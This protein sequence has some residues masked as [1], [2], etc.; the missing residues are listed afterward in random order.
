MTPPE[1][2][3]FDRIDSLRDRLFTWTAELVAIPTV[4]P[5]SGD[6]SAGIE[7]EGL[8]WFAARCRELGAAVRRVPVPP[9]VYARG[10]LI[11]PAGRSWK[12]RDNVVA[13]WVFGDGEGTCLLL[14]DHMDTV[15]TDGMTVPPFR[16]EVRDGR[17]YGRGSS[18][19]KGGLM[20]GLVAVK[21]LFDESAGLRGRVVFEAVVDEECNGGGA[22]T[23]ACCL[24]GVTGDLVLCLDGSA[25]SL[26]TGCNGV[27]TARLTVR[28]RAGHSSGSGSISAIDK[29]IAVKQ[30]V[31]AF[32]REHTARWPMCLVNVGIFR[33]GTLPAIVPG[34]AEI[35]LNMSYPPEDAEAAVEQGMPWGG[36]I[37]R[38]RFE[39]AM[40][41]MAGRDPWFVEKPVEVGWIKDLYPFECDAANRWVLLAQRAAS[42]AWGRPIPLSF[43]PAWFDAAHLARHLRAPVVGMGAGVSG[44]AH[45]SDEYVLLENLERNARAVALTLRRALA[46]GPA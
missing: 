3:L 30:A 15:G 20:S 5:Y 17:L 43:L 11:G 33:A 18:D 13:E 2:R 7:T 36:A 19:T 16:P 26:Y 38:A 34:E 12:D 8:D 39:Q 44:A 27:A 23:L 21:A 37:A 9:D 14:N 40:A 31:D 22:G 24:A 28:G 4:N 35:Q 32:G 42:D 46:G 10:G 6:A 45:S 41:D 25:G 1:R 29:A